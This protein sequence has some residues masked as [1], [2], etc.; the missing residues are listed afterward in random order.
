MGNRGPTRVDSTGID[1]KH[2]HKDEEESGAKEYKV[3]GKRN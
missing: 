2:S 1:E 3:E